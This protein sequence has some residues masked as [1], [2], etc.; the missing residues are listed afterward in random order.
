MYTHTY[1]N[2]SHFCLL[3]SVTKFIKVLKDFYILEGDFMILRRG[4]TD[5]QEF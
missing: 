5:W 4:K 2:I 1:T 3:L